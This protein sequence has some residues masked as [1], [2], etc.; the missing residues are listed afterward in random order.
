MKTLKFISVLSLL[1]ILAVSGVARAGE[2]PPD[3]PA[4]VANTVINPD[5][6]VA[7]ATVYINSELSYDTSGTITVQLCVP[8]DWVASGTL[9]GL[10]PSGLIDTWSSGSAETLDTISG[11]QVR[12][13]T[14]NNTSTPPS[15]W[16]AVEWSFAVLSSATAGSNRPV[17]VWLTAGNSGNPPLQTVYATV[18]SAPSTRYVGNASGDCDGNT[19]CHTGTSGLQDAINALPS[20]GG[21][22]IIGGQYLSGGAS[23]GAKNIILQPLDSSAELRA[24]NTTCGGGAPIVLNGGG[25]LTIDGL[26]LNGTS[27]PSSC[28]DG[29]LVGGSSA[30]NLTI[31]NSSGSITNWA[32]DGVEISSGAGG[33][34]TISNSTFSNNSSGIQSS[35]TLSVDGCTFSSNSSQGVSVNGGTATIENSTFSSNNQYGVY[36]NSGT[37]TLRG[38]TFSN[39]TDYGFTVAGGSAQAYANNFSGNNGGGFQAYVQDVDDAAKNWWG[40]YSDSSVGPTTDNINSYA[41]GWNARLGSD[42][43]NWSAGNGSAALGNAAMSGGS[44]TAVIID[45]ERASSNAPFGNGVPPYVNQS[46]SPFYDF[47]DTNGGTETWTVQLPIDTS[48]DCVSNVRN[49]EVAFQITPGT[50][51]TECNT[52][53]NPSCWDR[54]DANDITV[55]GDNLLI[56]MSGD[57]LN[58]TH[59][60]SGD[61][62]GAYDP[63]LIVLES[64]SASSSKDL[65]L[66]FL[67]LTGSVMMVV[68]AVFL[69]RRR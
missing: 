14:Y 7:G 25:N 53:N 52:A 46:C 8:S 19:P 42:V 17:R 24:D 28:N 22:V 4:E 48:T 50:Y 12:C 67:V 1:F 18:N 13:S 41:A 36:L 2:R 44:G 49:N 15:G 16:D 26:T 45:L 33:S 54:I 58:G 37:L 68:G 31:Q 56:S 11:V 38:N 30:G 69:I 21:T 62:S 27:A 3:M 10:T 51:D 47:Y 34:H 20:S 23:V 60:V 6:V 29:V 59:I 40:S 39:N 65:W 57:D 35:G 66:P 43:E 63:T 64:V 61:S 55:D 32:S 5:P 9:A